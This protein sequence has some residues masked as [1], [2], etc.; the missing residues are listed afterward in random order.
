MPEDFCKNSDIEKPENP[1]TPDFILFPEIREHIVFSR[2]SGNPPFPV[3]MPCPP[4]QSSGS[5]YID[6]HDKM[7]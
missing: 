6:P 4:Q 3:K 7:G 1:G 2:I 5:L